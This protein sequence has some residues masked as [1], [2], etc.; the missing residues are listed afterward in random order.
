MPL[1]QEVDIT[2]TFFPTNYF[3]QGVPLLD[4]HPQAA[5]RKKCAH[6][7]SSL[8]SPHGKN[9]ETEGVTYPLTVHT[10]A[11]VF[12]SKPS[13]VPLRWVINT[14]RS[15]YNL[16]KQNLLE[17]ITYITHSFIDGLPIQN[18]EN[19]DNCLRNIYFFMK[20][21]SPT[22]SCMSHKVKTRDMCCI[23]LRSFSPQ[24]RGW[25]ASSILATPV[26]QRLATVTP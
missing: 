2:A 22:P 5:K 14:F 9:Q 1:K 11:H 13:S 18:K 4:K 6:W 25:L 23:F 19:C 24:T 17:L 21:L 20:L 12:C 10:S 3:W 8:P 7:G 15:L 26:K 16:M